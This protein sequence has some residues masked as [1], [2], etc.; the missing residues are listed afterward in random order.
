[1][2]KDKINYNNWFKQDKN[3]A[4]WHTMKEPYS[5]ISIGTTPLD[6]MTLETSQS[7]DVFVNVKGSP[8][9]IYMDEKP[10]EDTLFEWNPGT[11]FEKWGFRHLF[12]SKKILDAYHKQNKTI[13]LHC[14][15]GAARSPI[16]AMT[17]LI[18]KKHTLDEVAEICAGDSRH[19]NSEK[20]NIERYFRLELIPPL[21]KL[22]EFYKRIDDSPDTYEYEPIAVMKPALLQY[23]P[24]HQRN[25]KQVRKNEQ[26]RRQGQLELKFPSIVFSIEDIINSS[27]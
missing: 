6:G 13:Y 18:S 9:H 16:T 24:G 7:F 23:A 12:W 21:E 11:E 27:N 26:I 25:I 5:N 20:R 3:T 4:R 19:T 2:D 8:Y 22:T 17:W 10:R 15:A 1:M 14:A